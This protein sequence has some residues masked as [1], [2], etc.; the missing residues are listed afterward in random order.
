MMLIALDAWHCNNFSFD[1][2]VSNAECPDSANQQTI[3]GA[4]SGK[5]VNVNMMRGTKAKP[6]QH[7]P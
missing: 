5:S 3:Y 2:L 1:A 6:G 4:V 7:F